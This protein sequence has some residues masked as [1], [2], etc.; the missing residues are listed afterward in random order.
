MEAGNLS[1]AAE[2]A[3]V[4]KSTEATDLDVLYQAETPTQVT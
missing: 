4:L 2:I 3:T 1:K